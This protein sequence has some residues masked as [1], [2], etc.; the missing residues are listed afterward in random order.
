MGGSDLDF[1]GQG[2]LEIKGQLQGQGHLEVK[3]AV[4]TG[5]RPQTLSDTLNDFHL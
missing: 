5:D 2:H 1:Q 3:V 4:L